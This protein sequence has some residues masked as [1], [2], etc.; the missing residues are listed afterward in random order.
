[1]T[2]KGVTSNPALDWLDERNLQTNRREVCHDGVNILHVDVP[3][4][5]L[6][7]DIEEVLVWDE[8]LVTEEG[9]DTNA[10]MSMIGQ[11][12]VFMAGDSSN[13]LTG[14]K[15]Q[16]KRMF[17]TP[18]HRLWCAKYSEES[19]STFDDDYLAVFGQAA[20][21]VTPEQASAAVKQYFTSN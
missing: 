16:F 7:V 9:D 20:G 1:M 13:V 17:N 5:E 14:E 12:A 3:P 18:H 8:S 2:S 21:S 4:A 11:A 15:W 19:G 10:L 6:L